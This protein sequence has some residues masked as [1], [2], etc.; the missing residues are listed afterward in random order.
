[1]RKALFALFVGSLVIPT[2]FAAYPEVSCSRD[3]V[4]SQYACHQCFDGGSIVDGDQLGFLNDV[5]VNDT[6]L[7]KLLYQEEQLAPK[8]H[9]IGGTKFTATKDSKNFWRPTRDLKDLASQGGYVLPA[10]QRVTWIESVPGAV[11]Q[12][13]NTPAKGQHAGMLVFGIT[14]HTI[15]ANGDVTSENRVHNE[16][17]LFTSGA[18]TPPPIKP[19]PEPVP[20]EITVPQTGPGLW[21]VSVILALLLGAIVYV[22][23]VKPAYDIYQKMESI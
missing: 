6:N 11:Y 19:D 2:S 5:W 13:S 1:M 7:P 18:G 10:G 14:E 3:A 9:S 8:M 16:C 17:V 21:V 20:K 23:T 15:L 22:A 4:Y 12:V